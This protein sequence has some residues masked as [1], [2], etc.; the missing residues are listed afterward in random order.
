MA[1][2]TLD[3]TV[4]WPSNVVYQLDEGHS[5]LTLATVRK[6]HMYIHVEIVNIVTF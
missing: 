4:L 1:S 2:E 3:E 5:A 6:F